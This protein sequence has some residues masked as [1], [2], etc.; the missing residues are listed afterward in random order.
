MKGKG[1]RHLRHQLVSNKGKIKDRAVNGPRELDPMKCINCMR[2]HHPIVLV[3][4]DSI[5]TYLESD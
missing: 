4:V 5:L 2:S 3:V 1:Y